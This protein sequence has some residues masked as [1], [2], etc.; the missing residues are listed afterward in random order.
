M[1][2]W[3]VIAAVTTVAAMAATSWEHHNGPEWPATILSVAAGACG[4]LILLLA[5][6]GEL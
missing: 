4:V 6:V 2:A 5:V 1:N 3:F